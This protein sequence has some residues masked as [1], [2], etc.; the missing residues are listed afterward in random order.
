M[1]YECYIIECYIFAITKTL[2]GE[3]LF[4][5]IIKLSLIIKINCIFIINETNILFVIL[6]N[7]LKFKSF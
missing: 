4:I 2:S 3:L 7:C 5:Y 1:L 6:P